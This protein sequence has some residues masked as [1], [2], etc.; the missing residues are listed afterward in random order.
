[1]TEM[2][3]N[4]EPANTQELARE[5]TILSPRFYTTDFAAMDRIDVSRVRGENAPELRVH[6][7]FKQVAHDGVLHDAVIDPVLSLIRLRVLVDPRA[8]EFRH[9]IERPRR[10]LAPH[11][12]QRSAELTRVLL[13]ERCGNRVARGSV[14]AASVGHQKQN[15]ALQIAPSLATASLR[16]GTA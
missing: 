15:L 12:H 2:T 5:D 10:A 13:L 7:A 11:V 4:F 6:V 9:F 8:V 16:L 14:T 1:M 3:H